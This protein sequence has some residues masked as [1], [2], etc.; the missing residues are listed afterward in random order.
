MTSSSCFTPDQFIACEWKY[1]VLPEGNQE[2]SQL[3]LRAINDRS[4]SLIP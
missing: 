1:D 3:D 2:V 4:S